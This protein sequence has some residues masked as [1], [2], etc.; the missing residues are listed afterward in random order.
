[1]NKQPKEVIQTLKKALEAKKKES[2]E[3]KNELEKT[4]K[5]LTSQKDMASKIKIAK[6]GAPELLKLK[7]NAQKA[8][9]D[10]AKFDAMQQKS[11]S[12]NNKLVEREN[13]INTLRVSNATKR[14]EAVRTGFADTLKSLNQQVPAVKGEKNSEPYDNMRKGLNELLEK[15]QSSSYKAEDRA[16]DFGDLQKLAQKYLDEKNKQW[17]PFPTQKRKD[18]QR[19][20]QD[21][22]TFCE[23]SKKLSAETPSVNPDVLHEAARQNPKVNP[24]MIAEQKFKDQMKPKVEAAKAKL[25]KNV[26]QPVNQAQKNQT[27]TNVSQLN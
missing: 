10:F 2:K 24:K 9:N 17:R 8:E 18:R 7:A 27:A 11:A 6:E 13:G 26:S 25:Q 5:E 15:M 3:I 21:I 12:I 20:A 14:E 16:K 23:N 4:G 22:V 1:M 19:L